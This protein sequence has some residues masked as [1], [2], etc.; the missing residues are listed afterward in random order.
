MTNRSGT[1]Y[2]GV[3]N[4]IMRRVSEH[5]S[6]T[7]KGFTSRYKMTSL[8]YVESTTDIQAA[9]EREKQLKGWTRKRKLELVRGRNP[10]WR[11]LS[12]EWFADQLARLVAQD[13]ILPSGQ[14]DNSLASMLEIPPLRPERRGRRAKEP[15][16]V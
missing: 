7:L 8:L 2:I 1:L 13:Q 16:N 6:G 12:E 11:D 5:K 4:D 3:T 15:T 10:H 9:I 14:N